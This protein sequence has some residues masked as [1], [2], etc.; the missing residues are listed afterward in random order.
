M[1]SCHD[2]QSFEPVPFGLRNLARWNLDEIWPPQNTGGQQAKSQGVTHR[3]PN[4]IDE[5]FKQM[6][7]EKLS[8]ID[9]WTQLVVI[10][11]AADDEETTV[12]FCVPR[13]KLRGE[14]PL[15]PCLTMGQL[16]RGPFSDHSVRRKLQVA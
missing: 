15:G 12:F 2:Q 3:F 6:V 14:P 11:L 5:V 1:N 9:S 8:Q 13:N 10:V 7:Q 4:N 16:P